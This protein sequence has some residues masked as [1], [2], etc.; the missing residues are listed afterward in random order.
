M[1]A[2]SPP[3]ARLAINQ[4][5]AAGVLEAL[6]GSRWRRVYVATEILAILEGE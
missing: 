6:P 4:L 5:A 2:V 1:L 3:T